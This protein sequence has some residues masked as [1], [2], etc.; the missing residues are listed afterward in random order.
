[1]LWR[2]ITLDETY[3]VVASDN[4][5]D[6]AIS[7]LSEYPGIRL[8]GINKLFMFLLMQYS[9]YRLEGNKFFT[10]KSALKTKGLKRTARKV[11]K[12]MKNASYYRTFILPLDDPIILR[13]ISIP[14]KGII[15]NYY[16]TKLS[17]LGTKDYITIKG[18]LNSIFV[19][20]VDRDFYSYVKK[21]V[22]V[23]NRI[24]IGEI[25][26]NVKICG[27]KEDE[28][29]LGIKMNCFS[30]ELTIELEKRIFILRYF[31]PFIDDKYHISLVPLEVV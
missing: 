8:E 28:N 20:Y 14:E 2:I 4:L 24:M 11:K 29:L 3:K 6:T 18:P 26:E 27:S 9:K 15:G 13:R 30:E 16:I 1:M 21:E 5:L 31:Y 17:T 7:F 10:L 23:A 12:K 22:A 25:Q 19:P